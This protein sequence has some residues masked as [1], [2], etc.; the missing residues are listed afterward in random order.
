MLQQELTALGFEKCKAGIFVIPV[1]DDVLGTIGLNTASD[2]SSGVLEINPVI[3]VRN[4]R[5]ERLVAEL[6]GDF[7]DEL[8]PPTIA[9]NIG[10]VS[11]ENRYRSYLFTEGMEI[12]NAITDMGHELR[13]HGLSFIRRNADLKALVETMQTARF[14]IPSVTEYRIP[15]GLLLL[16]DHSRAAAYLN[17]KLDE[18][19]ARKDPAAIRYK[20]FAIELSTRL[21][22]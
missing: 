13:T 3:G 18:I 6:C 22:S 10:Y 7:F 14:G 2:R 20:N 17:A 1:N 11:P 19:G 8:L 5:V 21:N 4:N 12:E 9:G 15:A 16:G